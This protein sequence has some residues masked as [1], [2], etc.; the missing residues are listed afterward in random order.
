MFVLSLKKAR[1]VSLLHPM[2][3]PCSGKP[4]PFYRL[5]LAAG[6]KFHKAFHLQPWAPKVSG[7]EVVLTEALVE[8][9]NTLLQGLVL[10]L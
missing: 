9:G 1:K 8:E 2:T 4:I 7:P 3:R 6:D 10:A 5:H